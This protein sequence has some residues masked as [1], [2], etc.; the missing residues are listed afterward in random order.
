MSVDKIINAPGARFPAAVGLKAGNLTRSWFFRKTG[1]KT[2]AS[3]GVQLAKMS[4]VYS[5]ARCCLLWFQQS[6]QW[7]HLGHS[8]AGR[9]SQSVASAYTP[10]L[11]T[12]LPVPLT[13]FQCESL[14]YTLSSN[15]CP[16]QGLPTHPLPSISQVPRLKR[17]DYII[18]DFLTLKTSLWAVGCTEWGAERRDF[19][20]HLEYIMY[21]VQLKGR[22]MCCTK[23]KG[24]SCNHFNA[25]DLVLLMDDY[26][27]L[28]HGFMSHANAILMKDCDVGLDNSNVITERSSGPRHTMTGS[29]QI[30]LS[31]K[32]K[33]QN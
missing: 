17:S 21:I 30:C 5:L 9:G 16:W 4:A 6:H 22:P 23:Q 28:S 10:G 3:V 25:S 32:L 8:S 14:L 18:R 7:C 13:L 33:K 26:K 12:V 29:S 15:L 20:T 27:F 1:Q 11:S 2:Y 19:N 24:A 31:A